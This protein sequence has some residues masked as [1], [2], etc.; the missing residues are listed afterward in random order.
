M[1]IE[2]GG[3]CSSGSPWSACSSPRSWVS[4]RCPRFQVCSDVWEIGG[5]GVE[6]SPTSSDQPDAA[7]T[8]VEAHAGSPDR[9]PRRCWTCSRT[10]RRRRPQRNTKWHSPPGRRNVTPRPT[11]SNTARTSIGSGADSIMLKAGESVF[12]KVTDT[13]LVEERRGPG[14]YAGHSQGVSIPIANFGG[15]SIRYRV[16]VNKGHYVS[17]TPTPTAIDTG[18]TFITNQRVIF[19]GGKQTRECVYAKLIGF[20]H[21][22]HTGSTTFSVSNRQKPT[23]IHYGPGIAGW[24]D[25]RLDL[26]LAHFKGTVPELVA[27]LQNGLD[28]I[29]KNRPPEPAVVAPPPAAAIAPAPAPPAAPVPPPCGPAAD[30]ERR[31]VRRPLE[32]GPSALVGR[33]AVDRRRPCRMADAEPL[34]APGPRS[35]VGHTPYWRHGGDRRR[36]L[37]GVLPSGADPR[38]RGAARCRCRRSSG[39]VVRF[40]LG[41]DAR[42]RSGRGSPDSSP[43][44]SSVRVTRDTHRRLPRTTVATWTWSPRRSPSA[45]R[46]PTSNGVCRGP[47]I[48]GFPSRCARA[49]TATRGIRPPGAC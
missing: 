28:V 31:L 40:D 29:D 5:I 44:R 43:A 14:H 19:Q 41:V 49:A 27:E 37:D 30:R 4:A 20:E 10:T 6:A 11:S 9:S 21:D 46:Q 26:G 35:S 38:S 39:V 17:G 45:P 1:R 13:S 2:T 23:T 36:T 25:F 32:G 3:S 48:M 12:G 7:P 18:T 16:G 33:H 15:R 24:F 8:A 47:V 22:D 42:P 34:T